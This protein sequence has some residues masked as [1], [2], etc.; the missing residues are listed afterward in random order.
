[1]GCSRKTGSGAHFFFSTSTTISTNLTSTIGAGPV[2]PATATS[3]RLL[4]IAPFSYSRPSVIDSSL[5]S[6]N[7][8]ELLAGDL[9]AIEPVVTQV[10]WDPTDNTYEFDASDGNMTNCQGSIYLFMPNWNAAAAGN[11]PYLAGTGFIIDIQM[12]N[13]QNNERQIG[14]LTFQFD[15]KAEPAWYDH[16]TS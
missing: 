16:T 3:W 10:L 9:Y 6:T 13:L 14:G 7:F 2:P 8:D 15:G 1:M 4:S 5:L 12:P 11:N